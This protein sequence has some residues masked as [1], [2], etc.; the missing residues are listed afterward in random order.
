MVHNAERGPSVSSYRILSSC[1]RRTKSTYHISRLPRSN[2]QQALELEGSHSSSTG[3]MASSAYRD[4][5]RSSYFFD[6][7][8]C[9]QSL[10]A[11]QACSCF[12]AGGG[13]K[14]RKELKIKNKIKNSPDLL[15]RNGQQKAKMTTPDSR[16]E[17]PRTVQ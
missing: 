15:D 4:L 12:S 2:A 14:K 6:T 10:L 7:R 17:R 9:M 16:G 3:L 11:R 5:Q 8:A 13:E 1:G